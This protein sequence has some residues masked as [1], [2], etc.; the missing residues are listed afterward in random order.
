MTAN[1]LSA[2]PP[3]PDERLFIALWPPP[4]L[5][6]ALHAR[7]AA[8]RGN[9]PARPIP[10]QR[11][12]LTLHFLGQVP[13][14][15]RDALRRVLQ[16]ACPAFELCIGRIEGWGHGLVVARPEQVPQQLTQLHQAMAEQLHGLGL[17]TEARA[18]RPHLTLARKHL[19]P[20]PAAGVQ[21]ADATLLEP[22]S[23]RV[24]GHVLVR[25]R[26][27]PDGGYDVLQ[28]YGHR[29]PAG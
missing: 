9:S 7:Y 26:T 14:S 23:W 19:G 20:W 4:N 5:A 1:R 3:I 10:P 24:Q 11:I 13:G 21:L 2:T 27:G 6:K 29:T 25:S 22:L 16:V 18:F 28:A 17:R 15:E 8:G 12:H